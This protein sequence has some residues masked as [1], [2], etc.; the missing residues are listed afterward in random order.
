MYNNEPILVTSRVLAEAELVQKLLSEEFS[1]VSISTNKDQFVADLEAC[2]PKVIVLAFE[3]LEHAELYYLK[4]Y[5]LSTIIHTLTHRTLIL[6]NKNEIKRCYVLCKK[7]YF[8]DYV[9]FWPLGYDAPR[10]LM[11]VHHALQALENNDNEQILA[12]MTALT[13]RVAELDS[14]LENS[15]TKGA[16]QTLSVKDSLQQAETGIN[17]A[18]DRFSK[19]LI[20]GS[21]SDTLEVKDANK[22]QKAI[23]HLHTEGIQN[24]LKQVS[25]SV[26]PVTEWV[27]TLKQDIAPQLEAVW[28]L[29][30]TAKLVQPVILIVDDDS[31]QRKLIGGLLSARNFKLMYAEGGE[32]ALRILR[33]KRADMILLD[34]SMAGM[35]GIEV[36]RRLKT[37]EVFA[38]IPVIMITGNSEKSVVIDCLKAGAVDFVVKPL[39]PKTLLKKIT[40]HLPK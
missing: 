37:N 31:F 38:A 11:S 20:D 39:Q 8:D 26:E 1:N 35:D 6:C 13:H 17:S 5:R 24:H 7:G 34:F 22:M 18:L 21:L 27:N 16:Q 30:K 14:Q 19:K 2:R 40:D 28:E 25:A 33:K 23:N 29:K 12:K 3:N 36:I 15:L 4:L 32:V 10:L 9:L